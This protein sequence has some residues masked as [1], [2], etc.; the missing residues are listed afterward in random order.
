M[1][2]AGALALGR[3]PGEGAGFSLYSDIVAG[4]AMG[5]W[6][7]LIN[8]HSVSMFLSSFSRVQVQVLRR[9]FALATSAGHIALARSFY[10][11]CELDRPSSSVC[12]R[13]GI[14]FTTV[15]CATTKGLVARTTEFIMF[16]GVE[17]GAQYRLR[18]IAWRRVHRRGPSSASRLTHY[19]YQPRPLT[20][21]N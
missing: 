15:E 11:T 1:A 9:T 21:G 14:S 8:V 12:A 2:P 18:A 5:I 19:D 3:P 4:E 7:G 17:L 16:M 10:V 20:S 6:K 13:E